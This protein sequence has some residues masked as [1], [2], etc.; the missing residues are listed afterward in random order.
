M[1]IGALV[2]EAAEARR[3]SAAGVWPCPRHS[4]VV[5]KTSEAAPL[6]WLIQAGRCRQKVAVVSGE[7]QGSGPEKWQDFMMMLRLSRLRQEGGLSPTF[8]AHP[9]P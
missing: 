9:T 8:R 1:W 6:R 3:S 2:E 7:L 4:T 5:P